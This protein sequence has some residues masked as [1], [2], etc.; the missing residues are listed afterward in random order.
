LLPRVLT[1]AE[2]IFS[3]VYIIMKHY[4]F[5]FQKV[6]SITEEI[7]IHMGHCKMKLGKFDEALVIFQ[8]LF[9]N[10]SNQ[11]LTDRMK[12]ILLSLIFCEFKLG[13]LE[14]FTEHFRSVIKLVNFKSDGDQSLSV[15]CDGNKTTKIDVIQHKIVNFLKCSY[16]PEQAQLFITQLNNVTKSCDKK[17]IRKLPGNFSNRFKSFHNAWSIN[18]FLSRTC[19]NLNRKQ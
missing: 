15:T 1:E 19:D 16:S 10:N 12:G 8:G 14:K 13:N 3:L 4:L 9:K 11:R 6:C 7:E 5:F 18:E 2:A 17:V